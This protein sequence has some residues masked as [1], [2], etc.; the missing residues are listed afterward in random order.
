MALNTQKLLP[1][2]ASKNNSALAI[3]SKPKPSSGGT[4]SKDPLINIL[5]KTILINKNI[6]KINETLIKNQI[7]TRRQAIKERRKGQEDRLERNK[8][9]ESTKKSKDDGNQQPTF[10]DRI[11]DFLTFTFLGWLFENTKKI[12]P[13]IL[14][15]V[16]GLGYV[17][18][19]L[20][21]MFGY[22]GDGLITLVDKGYEMWDNFKL[23][24]KENIDGTNFE[25]IFN[26]V[27]NNLETVAN[28]AVIATMLSLA[29]RGR[30]RNRQPRIRDNRGRDN[31]R[32]RGGDNKK[33][34]VTG[35]RRDRFFRNPFRKK[36]RIS[37][38][39][40]DRFFRNPFRK[41]P[42]PTGTRGYRFGQA[43]QRL[44]P[45]RRRATVTTGGSTRTQILKD[46]VKKIGSGINA[47][48]SKI[49]AGADITVN[50]VKNA[51]TKGK[52][53]ANQLIE[54]AKPLLGKIVSGGKSSLS[55]IKT[56][57]RPLLRPLQGA[58]RS[59][60]VVG[61]L[62]DF[63]INTLLFGDSPTEA[64]FKAV[65]AGIVGAVG[66]GLGSIIPGPGN[67]I[68]ATLGGIAGDKLGGYVYNQIFKGGSGE[69]KVSEIELNQFNKGGIAGTRKELTGEIKRTINDKKRLKVQ[70]VP[71]IFSSIDDIES[72]KKLFPKA[73]DN[74]EYQSPY[75][76]IKNN[77][78]L[79]K[80]VPFY[81]PLFNLFGKLFLGNRTNT[82]DIKIIS[83]SIAALIGKIFKTE[84]R[85]E[86]SL[87]DIIANLPKLIYKVTDRFLIQYSEQFIGALESQLQL[88]SIYD[89]KLIELIGEDKE[90]EK[91]KETKGSKGK[92]SAVPMM[93]LV[94]L[95]SGG[96]ALKNMTDQ[97]FSDLAYIV[98]HEALRGTDDEYAVAAAVLNRVT[99][100]RY[101]NTIMGVGTAPGQFEAVFSGKAYRDPELAKK[102]KSNQNKIIAALNKLD[103]RTDF[104]AFSSMGQFMG[105]TDIMFAKNGNFYHYAEQL[106]KSDPIPDTIP[107]HWRKLLGEGLKGGGSPIKT[108]EPRSF[109]S[110]Q[111]K[112]SYESGMVIMIKR[113]REIVYTPINNQR[114]G[115]IILDTGDSTL[116]P[117]K[118]KSFVK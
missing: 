72:I 76:F 14:D 39:R 15:S 11:K 79:M 69:K 27:I 75:D 92:D 83:T 64:A 118:F 28:L 89:S 59:I 61:A 78:L 21:N 42:T 77:T 41:K 5:K 50:A 40:R 20:S 73:K 93:P 8:K 65:F 33:P 68:G 55:A 37:G 111:E 35:S 91:T 63:G 106:R 56:L 108:R 4:E 17:G 34:K 66:S 74:S 44:N 86:E 103:G 52:F 43:L 116:S 26:P 82:S 25:K 2:S 88:K 47:A 62:I 114:M 90:D 49:K 113:E 38:T 102:L 99:D 54:L 104:K 19:F 30:G 105:D 101:P 109:K 112:T 80:K 58:L 16:K 97:D 94:P 84:L 60:P 9:K 110:L 46:Q 1:G 3:V 13:T 81:G 71:T 12:L 107:Q 67:I 85:K 95:G 31:T 23:W 51:I 98:S 32:T 57:A 96:G 115:S 100:P 10:L 48:G 18:E 22:L 70:K 53:K 24:K 7:K 29:D 87:Y 6:E 36:P 117:E 45:F